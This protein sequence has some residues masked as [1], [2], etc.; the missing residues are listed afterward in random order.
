VKSKPSKTKCQSGL[1]TFIQ[2]AKEYDE[3]DN[4]I[5]RKVNDFINKNIKEFKPGQKTNQT[6]T[7]HHWLSLRSVIMGQKNPIDLEKNLFGEKKDVKSALA[8]FLISSICLIIKK[9]DH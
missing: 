7:S 5:Y 1:I 9:K 6:I 3:E 4:Y 8:C 2:K